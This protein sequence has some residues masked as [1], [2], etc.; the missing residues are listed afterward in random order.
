[1]QACV[2]KNTVAPTSSDKRMAGRAPTGDK[3]KIYSRAG[4]N[5]VHWDKENRGELLI[6]FMK[7][8]FSKKKIISLC[9]LTNI[10]P[11]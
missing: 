4:Y 3:T 1:M 11:T 8:N 10:Q 9:W 2:S 6:T 5:M 7:I